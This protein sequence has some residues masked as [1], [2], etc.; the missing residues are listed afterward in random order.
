MKKVLLILGLCLSIYAQENINLNEVATKA[1]CAEILKSGDKEL[2]AKRGCC[3]WHGGVCDCGS[4]GRVICCDNTYS[5][6]CTCKGG[7]ELKA[8]IIR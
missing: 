8:E 1:E 6:S 4:N 3:S 2:I 5:P 7:N